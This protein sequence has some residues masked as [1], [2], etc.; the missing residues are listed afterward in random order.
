[1]GKKCKK[2]VEK[3]KPYLSLIEAKKI[4]MRKLSKDLGISNSAI[5]KSYRDV[6]FKKDYERLW[7]GLIS[8]EKKVLRIDPIVFIKYEIQF[9]LLNTLGKINLIEKNTES[10]LIIIVEMKGVNLWVSK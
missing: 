3:I 6:V 2:V 7:R 1:M 10:G 4:S 8:K 5:S 9:R